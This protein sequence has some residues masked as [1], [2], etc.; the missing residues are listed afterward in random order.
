V[1]WYSIC[2]DKI[3]GKNSV[4]A[5]HEELKIK[6][7]M[8]TLLYIVLI[9][10]IAGLSS[11]TSQRSHSVEPDD[12]YYN[13]SDNRKERK[14]LKKLEQDVDY[15]GM[16]NQSGNTNNNN[17][18]ESAPN[19]NS[20]EASQR[21]AG[22]GGAGNQS[23]VGGNNTVNN[24]TDNQFDM[25]DNY[26]YMYASRLRRFHGNSF[27]ND[28]YDPFFTNSFFYNQNPLMFGS[29]IYNGYNFWNPYSPWGWNRPGWGFGWNSWNGWNAGM[30]WGNN[31]NNPWAW[32][33]NQFFSPC[34]YNPWMM[35]AMCN[36]N[37]APGAWNSGFGSPMFFSTN[38]NNPLNLNTL[39][40]NT[41]YGARGSSLGGNSQ[42]GR[43]DVA[44]N[45]KLAANLPASNASTLSN[46]STKN[47]LSSSTSSK[48]LTS[49]SNYTS[50]PNQM[51]T[52]E[53]SNSVSAN[54]KEVNA[55]VMN[56]RSLNNNQAV[57]TTSSVGNRSD[58]SNGK[59]Y[60]P[61]PVKLNPSELRSSNSRSSV[62]N[63][64]NYRGSG[65][66]PERVTN[67]NSNSSRNGNAGTTNRSY[68]QG[69]TRSS[70]YS[71]PSGRNNY[72]N[73][74]A[75]SVRPNRSSGNNNFVAPSNNQYR[76]PQSPSYSSPNSGTRSGGSN[77]NSGG[78]NSGG[79]YNSG[80]SFNSGSGSG[81]RSSG[82]SFGGSSG[83]GGGGG[84][85]S[86]GSSG[87]GSPRR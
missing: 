71:T 85:R 28:Y 78:F 34:N 2:F 27:S 58:N 50:A 53:V 64:Y 29:S 57:I 23:N 17:T 30:G 11:C 33:Q 49:K 38:M 10:S 19:P 5:T 45:Q 82:G 59:I 39:D 7:A 55:P 86:G 4:P 48:D 8:K 15:A 77:N 9:T 74:P 42:I 51:V 84:T 32:N 18:E 87:G 60:K 37:W 69:N 75:N 21:Y 25:D 66:L 70:D 1:L 47:E 73:P 6:F 61:E 24:A 81:T 35:N 63:E 12:R 22:N 36:N 41:Y 80:G 14:K 44:L 3:A 40:Q 62:T 52:K 79:G 26:D 72:Y 13:S 16:A 20:S 43:T 31:F 67:N 56:S 54:K 68:N 46:S 83:S 76:A 65:N